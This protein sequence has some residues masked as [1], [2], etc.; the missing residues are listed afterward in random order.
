MHEKERVRPLTVDQR[1]LAA[2]TRRGRRLLTYA[3][4]REAG[5]SDESIYCRCKNGTLQRIHEAVYLVGAGALSWQE[6]IL[7]GVLAGGP[8]ALATSFSALR[9]F[10]MRNY[11]PGQILVGITVKTGCE[12]KGV[13]FVRTRRSPPSTTRDGV[14]CVV[15]E[16]ALLDVAAR[17]PGRELHKLLTSMW[18]QRLTTPQKVLDHMNDHGGRGVKGT[19]LLREVASLYAG[20][21]RPPGSEPEADFLFLLCAGLD[22]AGIEHPELQF[23]IDVRDGT[24]KVVPDF[25]WPIRR[26]VVEMKGLQA[27][28]DYLIQDEDVERESA[29]RNA[30]WDLDSVTPRAMRE[31]PDRTIARI[32]RFLQTPNAHWQP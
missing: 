6:E 31:R 13:T 30:G 32:I 3:E 7:A 20:H 16:Q 22:A 11:A 24:E 23:A 21:S 25:V 4:L 5:V 28:G 29:I 1:I 8:S 17:L 10:G 15:A 12:A 19:V 26:K 18:R 9:L 2:V 27:H 14:P